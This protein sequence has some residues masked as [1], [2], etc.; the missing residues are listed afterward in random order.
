MNHF[1]LRIFRF[2]RVLV[3]M[4]L[5]LSGFNSISKSRL[6]FY[7]LTVSICN[8]NKKNSGFHCRFFLYS[9]FCFTGEVFQAESIDKIFCF[10]YTSNFD[11]F[12]NVY[13]PT[14][15]YITSGKYEIYLYILFLNIYEQER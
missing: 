9:F 6:Y 8:K 15:L 3:I 7:F 12:R 14:L 1:C 10:L 11:I 5:V 2:N 4:V 13:I